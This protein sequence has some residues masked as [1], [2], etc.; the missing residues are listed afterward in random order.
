MFWATLPTPCLTPKTEEGLF[1]GF[2]YTSMVTTGE[3]AAVQTDPAKYCRREVPH[4]LPLLRM[5]W[6]WEKRQKGCSQAVVSSVLCS[7]QPQL[8]IPH[9]TTGLPPTWRGPSLGA[10][11]RQ[12]ASFW[13][14]PTLHFYVKV[15]RSF[16]ILYLIWVFCFLF[17]L[18]LGEF[19]FIHNQD[20][21]NANHTFFFMNIEQFILLLGFGK[22]YYKVNSILFLDE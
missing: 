18:R 19:I 21:G 15:N 4:V 13:I 9:Q 17:Y 3:W 22:F 10:P 12:T 6:V 11:L 1:L 14:R 5:L 7:S 16:N 20:L 2:P 8:P